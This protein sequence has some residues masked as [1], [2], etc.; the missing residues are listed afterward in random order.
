MIQNL[1][2]NKE[3]C[4]EK[5]FCSKNKNQL[6][7]SILKYFI[8][9]LRVTYSRLRF[10]WS[11]DVTDRIDFFWGGEFPETSMQFFRAVSL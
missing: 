10:Y 11:Y 1:M 7:V 2:E 5:N 9:F 3:Y 6:P 4:F 8:K